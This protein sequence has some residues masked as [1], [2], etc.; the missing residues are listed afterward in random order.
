LVVGRVEITVDL[1]ATM[2]T[3]MYTVAQG[4]LDHRPT[5]ATALRCSAWV[6]LDIHPTS[7]FRIVA[8]I[9]GQL[10]PHCI[11]NAFRQAVIFDHR[12]DSQV[13]E[14]DNAEAID[15]L[16]AFLMSKV[17]ASIG[18]PLMDTRHN[19]AST[20]SFCRSLRLF[21]QAALCSFQ[22]TLITPKETWVGNRFA[23]RERGE[24]LKTDIHADCGLHY[25]GNRCALALHGKSDKPLATPAS[26]QRDGFDPALDGSMQLD[27]HRADL[28]E[29]QLVPFEPCAIPVLRIGHRVV[30]TK[31]LETR[32]SGVLFARFG[33]PKERLECQIDPNLDVLQDL[34]MHPLEC[35]A[36]GFPVR[37]KGLRII[38]AKRFLALFPRITTA[39]S[40]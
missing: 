33:T 15:Q 34:G 3:V 22:V 24:L 2:K 39:A 13:L 28:R 11:R 29:D 16:S 1:K 18:Y 12:C 23:R 17:L 32:V 36:F 37:K 7:I 8:R 10:S 25:V 5:A 14:H 21:A 35:L 40:V 6:N 20:C 26:P 4:F 9:G 27:Q 19:S 38:Q 31:A 30:P